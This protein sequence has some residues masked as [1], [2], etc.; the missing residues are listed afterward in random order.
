[1]IPVPSRTAIIAAIVLALVLIGA[2]L[3][4]CSDTRPSTAVIKATERNDAAKD[5]AAIERRAD[6]ATISNQQQDRTNAI[7]NAPAGQTGPATRALNCARWMQQHPAEA[8]PAG[9]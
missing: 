4:R 6:D 8:R 1:M 9:C 7:D 2:L 3:A 5:Q